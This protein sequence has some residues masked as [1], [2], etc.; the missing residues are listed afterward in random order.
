MAMD[1]TGDYSGARRALLLVPFP[2]GASIDY[3]AGAN[4]IT[5]LFKAIY[6]CVAANGRIHQRRRVQGGNWKACF[7]CA[8]GLRL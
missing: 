4:R 7:A 5:Y 8:L 6:T 2:E 1:D 3:A